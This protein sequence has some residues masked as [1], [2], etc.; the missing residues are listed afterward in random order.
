MVS[1]GFLRHGAYLVTDVVFV[2]LEGGRDIL[3]PDPLEKIAHGA[4]GVVQNDIHPASMHF[5]NEGSPVLDLA[6]VMVQKGEIQSAKAIA[7]PGR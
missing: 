3:R 1:G 6:M 2:P 5:A 4:E 7:G